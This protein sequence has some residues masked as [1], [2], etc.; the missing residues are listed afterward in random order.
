MRDIKKLMGRMKRFVRHIVRVS[1]WIPIIWQTQD[2]DYRYTLDILSHSLGELEQHLLSHNIHVGAERDA[3]RIRYVCQMINRHIEEKSSN[4][5]YERHDKKWGKAVGVWIPIPDSKFS[6]WRSER[7][8]ART[9]QERRQERKD[10]RRAIKK[11]QQLEQRDWN[12]IWDT[13]K[14]YGRGWWC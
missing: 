1:R 11:G 3:K 4:M 14:K 8:L 5:E 7:L 6:E 12:E 9:E 2:F 13:I 10:F